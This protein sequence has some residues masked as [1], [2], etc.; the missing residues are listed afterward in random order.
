MPF[1]ACH[2]CFRN[3]ENIRIREA[4]EITRTQGC[5]HYQHERRGDDGNRTLAASR[6][7]E[8]KEYDV[9]GKKIGARAIGMIWDNRTEDGPTVLKTV[10]LDFDANLLLRLLQALNASV[11]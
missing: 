10:L 6:D 2:D 8:A 1:S 5:A 4:Y 9:E 3:Q 7:K 11:Y